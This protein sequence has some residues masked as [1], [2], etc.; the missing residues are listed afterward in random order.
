MS[1]PTRTAFPI[2]CLF[3]ACFAV[4]AVHASPILQLYLE[5][6]TYNFASE[7]WEASGTL[8]L[9][10]IAAEPVYDVRLAIAYDSAFDPLITLTPTSAGTPDPAAL[11]TV[12]DGST[13]LLGGGAP[14]PSHGMYGDG[15]TWQEFALGDMLGT[16][17]PI[18]DFI[19]D[20][21]TEFPH[22]GQ[23]NR[24]E[25]GVVGDFSSLHFD[26]YDHVFA[27]N[28][29]LYVKAPFSHDADGFPPVV[30]EP[31]TWMLFSLGAMSA[32]WLRRRRQVA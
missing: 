20:F 12:A 2:A 31:A 18:G 14:L 28:H 10:A 6:G 27:G 4:S 9:W 15:T 17:D 23:I 24:Y 5:G 3:V 30:P 8:T 19:G 7:S 22:L 13:P 21:P 32:L 25:I 29:A 1:S 16:D 11:Q 26:L